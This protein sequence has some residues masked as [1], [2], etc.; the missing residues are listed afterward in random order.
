MTQVLDSDAYQKIEKDNLKCD[1]VF[2]EMIK[3][4]PSLIKNS[5]LLSALSLTSH[6]FIP[7]VNLRLKQFPNEN[8]LIMLINSFCYI[9]EQSPQLE[10]FL[11][12][13][14]DYYLNKCFPDIDDEDRMG[15]V[16]LVAAKCLQNIY[17]SHCNPLCN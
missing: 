13:Y 15:L 10:S 2:K 6:M 7:F 8:G 1:E 3:R 4:Y 14:M 12:P 9:R 11:K 16:R 5:G 17:L